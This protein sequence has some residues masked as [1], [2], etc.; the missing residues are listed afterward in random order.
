M[1]LP[2][3]MPAPVIRATTPASDGVASLNFVDLILMCGNIHC[4]L[5]LRPA[6]RNPVPDERIATPAGRKLHLGTLN[7]NIVTVE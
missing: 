2:S 1:A 5:T 6:V 4:L 7:R 3:R